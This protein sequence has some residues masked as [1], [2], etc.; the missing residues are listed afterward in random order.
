MKFKNKAV[1]VTGGGTGIGRA[2]CLR[3]AREGAAVVV[4]YSKSKTQAEEVVG[5]IEGAGGPRLGAPGR[6][7]QRPAGP[8]IDRP[9]RGTDGSA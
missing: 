3:F 2:M 6:R 7:F 8:G 4:N 1:V 9:V 5:I